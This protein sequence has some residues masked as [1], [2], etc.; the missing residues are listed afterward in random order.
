MRKKEKT[1]FVCQECGYESPK[2]MGQCICGSWNTMVE[3]RDTREKLA[4]AVITSSENSRHRFD[5]IRYV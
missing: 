5:P 2:W 4:K 1:I 3:E